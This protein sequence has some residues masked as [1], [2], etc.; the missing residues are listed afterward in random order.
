[1]DRLNIRIKYTTD[2]KKFQ[3]KYTIIA[4][5]STSNKVTNTGQWIQDKWRIKDKKGHLK[6]HVAVVNVKIKK[7]LS[8]RVT[9]VQLLHHSNALAELVKNY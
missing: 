4:I 2:S 1:M 8:M 5:Y 6:I 7:I 9:D 3:D